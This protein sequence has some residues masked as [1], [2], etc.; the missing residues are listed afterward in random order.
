MKEEILKLREEGKSY[1]EIQNILGC[2]KSTISYYCGSEQK[3][4]AYGRVKNRRQDKLL[5]KVERYKN[6]NGNLKFRDFQ[7]RTDDNK[8]MSQQEK[9]FSIKEAKEWIGKNPTCYLTG[10]PIDL[11]DSQSYH[12][13]HIVPVTKGGK[14]TLKNMGLLKSD[15]NKMKSD[16][17][18]EELLDNCVKILRHNGFSV[19]EPD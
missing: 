4:K 15:I 2:S 18:V 6:R 9:N 19:I 12:L 16:L 13:D 14:N 1:S 11:N 17:T 8:L 10:E 3:T 7:R 5:E